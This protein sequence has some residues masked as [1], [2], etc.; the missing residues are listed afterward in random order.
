MHV[1]M[2]ANGNTIKKGNVK[3]IS[4]H[5][6][7]VKNVG[8][9]FHKNHWPNENIYRCTVCSKCQSSKIRH[10]LQLDRK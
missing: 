2:M 1:L 7:K 10:L 6:L 3:N 4:S 9:K 5:I 8:V